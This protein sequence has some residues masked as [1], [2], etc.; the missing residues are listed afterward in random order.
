MR[1]ASALL[2]ACPLAPGGVGEEFMGISG[3]IGAE[4]AEPT[5]LLDA[6]VVPRHMIS[7]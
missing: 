5:L 1:I 7:I 2:E 4:A 3:G 6:A